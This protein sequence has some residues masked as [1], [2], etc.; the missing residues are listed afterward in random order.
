MIL[1]IILFVIFCLLLFIVYRLFK[2]RKEHH[3]FKGILNDFLK[4][5]IGEFEN[6]KKD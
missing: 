1:K 5:M 4:E 6:D 3:S 2:L